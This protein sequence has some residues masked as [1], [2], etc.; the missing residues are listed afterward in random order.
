MSFQVNPIP[1]PHLAALTK[2]TWVLLLCICNVCT[3]LR[4]HCT[5]VTCDIPEAILFIFIAL[6][7]AMMLEKQ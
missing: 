7:N 6:E 3:H 4:A 2:M 1:P 5:V